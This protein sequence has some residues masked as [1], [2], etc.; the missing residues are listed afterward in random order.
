MKSPSR[1]GDDDDL[2][3]TVLS[4]PVKRV[5]KLHV[6]PCAFIMHDPP[7]TMELDNQHSNT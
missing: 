5:D 4:D 2:V 3:S 6:W 7:G 1:A